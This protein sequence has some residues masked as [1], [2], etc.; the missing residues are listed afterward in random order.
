MKPVLM[1]AA[2]LVAA[3]ASAQTARPM[4][5]Y[6]SAAAIRD[7]CLTFAEVND[8]DVAIAVYDASGRLITFAFADGTSTAVGDIAMWK[9]KS[10]A[11]YETDTATTANWGGHGPGIAVWEG[12]I[13]F[14]TA[15][16]MAL[17]GVGVSGAA[18]ADDVKCAQAGVAVAGLA[19]APPEND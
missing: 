1:A 15:D 6:S 12:G 16:G 14:F 8:M 3:S 5:D 10:A 18:S 7:G 13:P 4:L 17:G 2:F 19:L 9:G 11:V